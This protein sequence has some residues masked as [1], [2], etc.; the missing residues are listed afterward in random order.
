MVPLGG[1]RKGGAHLLS[2]RP[3]PHSIHPR[4]RVILYH[5]THGQCLGGQRPHQLLLQ[6]INMPPVCGESHPGQALLVF[7]QFVLQLGPIQSAPHRG[8]VLIGQ[9]LPGRRWLQCQGNW[10]VI[11]AED[12]RVMGDALNHGHQCFGQ[13]EV[14]QPPPPILQPFVQTHRPPGIGALCLGMQCAEYIYQS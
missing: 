8:H 13:Q 5:M 10:V 11:G 9:F 7:Q 2:I 4:L 3:P 1:Q 12:I 6:L 14:V